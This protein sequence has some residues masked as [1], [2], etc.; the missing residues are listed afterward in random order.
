MIFIK[1]IFVIVLDSLGI[2]EMHD[3]E[4]FGDKFSNTL[5]SLYNTKKLNIPNLMKLGITKIEGNE[6]F[7]DKTE[8]IASIARMSEKSNGKDTTVGHWEIMGVVSEK[9]FPTYPNG[10]PND[11]IKKFEEKTEKNVLCNKPYSGTQVL[12]DYGEEH[13]NTNSLIVYTSA[14]SVFQIAA[15]E[16]KTPINELYKYCEIARSILK[17]E[18]AVA[19]VIARPFVGEYPHYTRTPNRHDYSLAPPKM[20]ALDYIKNKGFD[21]ISVGKINDIF[22][23]QGITKSIPTKSNKDGMNKTTEISKTNFN[24]L[25]FVNLVDFDSTYGHRNDVNGYTEALNEFDLWLGDFIA[26]MN[27]RD[28]LFVTADHGCDPNTESTDHS[29]EY[30][31]MLCYGK[32]ITQK[33]LGTRQSF[34][35]IGKTILDMLEIE[36]DIEGESFY[37]IIRK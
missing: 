36:N 35:D 7:N 18:H 24:G 4:A 14:D 9:P 19:R 6:Y 28:I 8:N 33:N 16:Q 5:K 3:A 27:D 11:I 29:R 30:T 1:R 22:S 37:S 12:I 10:F 32:N 31:P 15:H 17:D 2:G 26:N 25:C 13:E 23:G 34:A 21:V 20:T